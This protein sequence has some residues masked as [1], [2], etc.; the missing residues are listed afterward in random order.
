MVIHTQILP[1]L[2]LSGTLKETLVPA[3]ASHLLNDSYVPNGRRLVVFNRREHKRTSGMIWLSRTDVQV[4]EDS[5]PEKV[6]SACIVNES[7]L[8]DG[9]YQMVNGQALCT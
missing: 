8:Q 2:Q 6:Q 1:D 3:F 4:G 5:R 7:R 9:T